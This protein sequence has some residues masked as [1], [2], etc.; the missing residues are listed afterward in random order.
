[1]RVLNLF[2]ASLV[3]MIP[4]AA[5]AQQGDK[6]SADLDALLASPKAPP[7][8]KMNVASATSYDPLVKAWLSSNLR[9]PYSAVVSQVRGPRQTSF[10]PDVWTKIT[11]TAVCYDINAKNAYGGYTGIKR[12]LFIFDAERIAYHIST[13]DERNNSLAPFLVRSECDIVGG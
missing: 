10:K 8:A 4:A 1:M 12:H 13:A 3:A 6:L 9:D 11:G 7:P 2:A 5:C